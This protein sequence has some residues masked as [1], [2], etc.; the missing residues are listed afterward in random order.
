MHFTIARNGDDVQ[1]NKT[2]LLADD[3]NAWSCRPFAGNAASP[4][5]NCNPSIGDC[6]LRI[7]VIR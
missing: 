4:R 1:E 3:R 7:A 5:A 6:L 2:Q